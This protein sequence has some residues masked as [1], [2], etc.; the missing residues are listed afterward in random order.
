M[1]AAV[2]QT[3]LRNVT[4]VPTCSGRM[5]LR[6]SRQAYIC[7]YFPLQLGYLKRYPRCS[8]VGKF[9]TTDP[10]CFIRMREAQLKSWR[11]CSKVQDD[12]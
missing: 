9:W 6:S 5:I 11:D 12:A 4:A 2:I 1:L 7:H 8:G 10:A 3:Q